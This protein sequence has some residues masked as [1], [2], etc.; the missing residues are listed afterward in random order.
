M[1]DRSS[2]RAYLASIAA[3]NKSADTRRIPKC[4]YQPYSAL[5]TSVAY[6]L[7]LR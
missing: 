1:A 7:T 6:E 2:E 4:T 3:M 5:Y